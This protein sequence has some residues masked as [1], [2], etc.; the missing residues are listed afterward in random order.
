[1]AA[2]SSMTR[3]LAPAEIELPF[4]ADA[5]T[6]KFKGSSTSGMYGLP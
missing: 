5:E 4:A 6:D 3:M 1:M 2:S